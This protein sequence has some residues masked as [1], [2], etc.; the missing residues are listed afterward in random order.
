MTVGKT[1]NNWERD[2]GRCWVAAI[3]Q[4]ANAGFTWADAA[5]LF[6][7]KT[8]TLKQY[9]HRSGLTFPWQG[10][11]S[12]VQREHQRRMS[13]GNQNGRRPKVYRYD[14]KQYT[15]KELSRISGLS[16]TTIRFRLY[17]GWSV[18]QSVETPHMNKQ[19]AGRLGGETTFRRHGRIRKSGLEGLSEQKPKAIRIET[20]CVAH[21]T[22]GT[23]TTG[24]MG[25]TECPS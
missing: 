19:S 13:M 24:N 3:E 9:C 20:N 23:G 5:D 7:V 18:E 2:N 15:L 4:Y 25:R 17:K 12:P 16:V 22:H 14:G 21:A 10:H 1:L 11:K 6:G 8:D